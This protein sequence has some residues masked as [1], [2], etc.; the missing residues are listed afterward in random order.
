MELVVKVTNLFRAWGV[1]EARAQV[2]IIAVYE[3]FAMALATYGWGNYLSR[4]TLLDLQ[5]NSNAQSW[6]G[7]L[8]AKN[9]VAGLIMLACARR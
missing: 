2:G 8:K 9:Y 7:H 5:D 3:A 1:P 4:A 6:I